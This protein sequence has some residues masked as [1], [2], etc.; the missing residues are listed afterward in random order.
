MTNLLNFNS[1]EKEN[2]SLNYSDIFLLFYYRIPVGIK[3]KYFLEVL[4]LALKKILKK[5]HNFHIVDNSPWPIITSISVFNLVLG[6]TGVL[7]RIDYGI[8]LFILGLLSTILSISY[9]FK[10]IIMEATYQGKHTISV[11]QNMRSGITWFIVSE[12]ML[13]FSFF[14]AF[15]HF[16]LSPSIEIGGVWPPASFPILNPYN[17]PLLNTI[18]LIVSGG[19][20][21]WAHILLGMDNTYSNIKIFNSFFN[22]IYQ[23]ILFNLKQK[24]NYLLKLY[25]KF[26]EDLNPFFLTLILALFFTELQ[27]Y[28]YIVAPFAISDSVFGSVFY[29]TTGLHGLH[30]IVGTIFI[31]VG[32]LRF[33]KLH[34]RKNHHVGFDGSA[35]YWHFVDVVWILLY[36][37]FYVWSFRINLNMLEDII[38]T[39]ILNHIIDLNTLK[40]KNF[41]S[42]KHFFDSVD[43]FNIII[44]KFLFN[45]NIFISF[46]EMSR[47]PI[48]LINPDVF[49]SFLEIKN[50]PKI[51]INSDIFISF[52][53]MNNFNFFVIENINFEPMSNFSS[54]KKNA[55]FLE[56][57]IILFLDSYIAAMKNENI[58]PLT[59]KGLIIILIELIKKDSEF[60]ENCI[61]YICHRLDDKFL[62]FELKSLIINKKNSK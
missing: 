17:I 41:I 5:R 53:E 12:I 49:I 2:I 13:F 29:M 54:K 39:N 61:H 45:S 6:L 34:F 36:L 50:Y 10:D 59:K 1:R 4:N 23:N 18:I 60:A 24:F 27:A 42:Y 58:D 3:A 14:W 38:K 25:L 32:F 33:L 57:D 51:F 9:W 47:Y 55:F 48:L 19:T 8:Y 35:W 43:F 28:E 15:F 40:M 20:L 7:H 56:E 46:L 22:E 44:S 37:L 16:S 31:S 21:T 52:L 11:Q 30:V 26:K 62:E